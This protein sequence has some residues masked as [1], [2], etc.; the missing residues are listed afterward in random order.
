VYNGRA[1]NPLQ[2]F[3]AGPE[4]RTIQLVAPH[5]ERTI[6]VDE[7]KG[8]FR[9]CSRRGCRMSAYTCGGYQATMCMNDEVE[10]LSEEQIEQI[11]AEKIREKKKR[12]KEK[13]T[14]RKKQ[15]RNK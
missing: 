9:F 5:Q 8:R 4:R 12:K 10:N 2:D 14:A 11:E 6:L 1:E 3:P 7:G 13:E 15:K